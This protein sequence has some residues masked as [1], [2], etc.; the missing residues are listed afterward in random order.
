[1]LLTTCLASWSDS[2]WRNV[3]FYQ[4]DYYYPTCNFSSNGKYSTPDLDNEA[5]WYVQDNDN[6][7]DI[8][9]FKHILFLVLLGG[10][11]FFCG[12]SLYACSLSHR[13]G[14]GWQ[15]VGQ[16]MFAVV[17]MLCGFSKEVLQFLVSATQY[18]QRNHSVPLP[19]WIFRTFL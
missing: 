2:Q 19:I 8:Y 6:H 5:K 11:S 15:E 17:T 12:S 4:H 18:M 7:N 9:S 3:I 10:R 1:M 14:S 16:H 13:L